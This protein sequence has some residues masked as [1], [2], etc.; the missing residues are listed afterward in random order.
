M[1]GP[2]YPAMARMTMVLLSLVLVVAG[3]LGLYYYTSP[4]SI[5]GAPTGASSSVST[6][7]VSTS[8]NNSV[9]ATYLGYIPAGYSLAPHLVN[10]PLFPCPPGMSDKD[11]TLFKQTCGNGVCDPNER[12]DTCPIDCGVS[13]NLAC[14][15]YT[16]RAGS[17]A[18]VCQAILEHG[19][20]Y[21]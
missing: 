3:A 9:W 6:S 13:G 2:S 4:G 8:G 17:P 19:Q 1:K 16:G 20:G 12:C 21:G 14:D 18:T 11:C 5:G 15:P 10:S 7:G